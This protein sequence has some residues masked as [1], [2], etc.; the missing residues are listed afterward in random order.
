MSTGAMMNPPT[1]S[2]FTRPIAASEVLPTSLGPAPIVPVLEEQEE[3]DGRHG[4][5][6]RA[7]EKWYLQVLLEEVS[8]Q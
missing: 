2:L 8:T 4:I 7:N 5:E 1:A 3:K 6:H